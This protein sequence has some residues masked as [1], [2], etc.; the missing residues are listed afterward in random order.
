MYLGVEQVIY[1]GFV[2]IIG[3]DGVVLCEIFEGVGYQL[4]VMFDGVLQVCYVVYVVDFDLVGVDEIDVDFVVWI[5]IEIIG[6]VWIF[7]ECDV[8]KFVVLWIFICGVYE[9]VVLFVLCQS[10]LWGFVGVIVVEYFELW[11]GLVDFVINDDLGE[12]GLVFVELFVKLSKLIL[13][14]CDG[15][16]FVLVLVFVCGELVCKFLQC[17]FDVVYFII[18]GLGVFGLLMVD[19]FVDCGVY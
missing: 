6:L 4:V 10:F 18:G 3:D 17:R 9:L 1:L 19:W 16:V 2:V 14:C 7:V 8:D 11:G 5:C 15:V 12:F 13:V